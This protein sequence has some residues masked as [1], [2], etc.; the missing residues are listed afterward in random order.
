MD[1]F[2]K[3]VFQRLDNLEAELSELREVTWPVCQGLKDQRS[4]YSNIREKRGFF[5]FLDID[6]VKRLLRLKGEFMGKYPALDAEELRQVLVV[7]PRPDGASS[8]SYHQYE[9]PLQSIV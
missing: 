3:H 8:S 6:V 1:E 7:A 5:R 9:H 2:H 4:Q